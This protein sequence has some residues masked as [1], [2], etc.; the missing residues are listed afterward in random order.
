[1]GVVREYCCSGRNW[2]DSAR[3]RQ[4]RSQR[5]KVST[6]TAV[7]FGSVVVRSRDWDARST[8][9][10]QRQIENYY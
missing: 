7:E 10:K 1:M 9:G 3:S 6:R 4:G 2:K 5:R 8:F